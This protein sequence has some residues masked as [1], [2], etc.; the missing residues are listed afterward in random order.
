VVLTYIIT[1]AFA[2]SALKAG[3][4]DFNDRYKKTISGD[5]IIFEKKTKPLSQDKQKQ[6]VKDE[7][8]KDIIIVKQPESQVGFKST[9]LNHTFA[10]DSNFAFATNESNSRTTS[11]ATNLADN[12]SA[13]A[14]I[15]LDYSAGKKIGLMDIKINSNIMAGRNTNYDEGEDVNLNK[16]Y[17]S[18]ESDSKAVLEVGMI[19]PVSE[20]LRLDA[21]TFAK[22]TGG[23]DGDMFRMFSYPSSGSF[24]SVFITLPRSPMASG[25][26]N[27]AFLGTTTSTNYNVP[28]VGHG[29]DLS[30]ANFY[31]KRLGDSKKIGSI[32]FGLSFFPNTDDLQSRRPANTINL[33]RQYSQISLKNAYSLVANYYKEFADSRGIFAA[34][35]SNENAKTSYSS[36]PI[37]GALKRNNLNTTTLGLNLEYA[38]F[39][40][41]GSYSNWGRSL[42]YKQN[43][44]NQVVQNQ[45]KAYYYTLGTGY[46]FGPSGISLGY[47]KSSFSGNKFDN[48]TLSTDYELSSSQAHKI[49]YFTELS[50]YKFSAATTKEV[51]GYAI[52]TG[53]AISFK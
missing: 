16:L 45:S 39:V 12:F 15:S 11:T 48:I 6:E 49:K 34:T 27:S 26:A 9:E 20:N 21:S 44:Q 40:F 35:I 51:N 3:A 13:R 31:T 24:G 50:K 52:L 41:G 5:Y 8:A 42:Y 43:D 14:N 22:G 46:M 25:F 2:L 23:I 28:K 19:K 36:S 47:I 18:L 33:N 10:I 53:F 30:G 1:I 17:L 4:S 38:G 7:Q 37:A 29:D 32:K